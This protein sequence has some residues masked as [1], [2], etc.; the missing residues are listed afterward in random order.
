MFRRMKPEIRRSA[1]SVANAAAADMQTFENE[2]EFFAACRTASSRRSETPAYSQRL[3]AD[4]DQETEG[5]AENQR[6]DC[7][8]DGQWTLDMAEKTWKVSCTLKQE[9]MQTRM[10]ALLVEWCE[11][12]DKRSSTICYDDICFAYDRPNSLHPVEVIRKGPH[13]NCYVRIPHP[14][15]DPVLQANM[16]SLQ[17]FYDRTFWCNLNVYR[18]FQAAIAI[19]KR[20]FNVDRCFIGISPGGVGQSLYSLHLSEM[21]K[22]NHSF[23]DPNIWHLDEEL[24]K[25]V[26]S[27]AK[28][29]VNRM[30]AF[31]GVSNHNFNSLFRRSFAW[32]AKAR[33]VHRK[34]LTKYPEHEKD[35]I[36]EAD[37]SLNKFLTT[38]QAS[39][40][41]LKLQWAFE[42]DFNK[43]DCYQLIENYCNGGDGCLT[44]DVMRDA[45]GLPV[46]DCANTC[47][48]GYP[49]EASKQVPTDAWAGQ[50]TTGQGGRAG[51]GKVWVDVIMVL[52]HGCPV[53]RMRLRFLT[54]ALEDLQ[55]EKASRDALLDLS[56]VLPG[57]PLGLER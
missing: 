32:K 49:E 28:L 15:L 47:K 13:N 55:V 46:R 5:L 38:S 41:G 14:L 30:M 27:F 52:A 57:R 23:F 9:L 36:F 54:A 20:G 42:M 48:G 17:M 11:S 56:D 51:H 12:E 35:G 2:A 6:P 34:F 25:Q 16:Q 37:P 40:A 21:Y 50:G 31:V 43:D 53:E 8:G 45:C 24:R 3:D 39:V 1:D 29:E 22:H 26:E 4:A 7:G 18:C 44:E 33:F 10:I 19:A